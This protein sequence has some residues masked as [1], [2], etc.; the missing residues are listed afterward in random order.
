MKNERNFQIE[1]VAGVLVLALILALPLEK[2]EVVVLL[3]LI[4]SVIILETVNT[5]V[6]RMIDLIKPRANQQ[7]G[8][9]K[10]II[11]AVVFLVSVMSAVVGA[12][13]FWP[14]LF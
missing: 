2:W 1:V 12:I 3:V 13:I 14:Y 11:A 5:F 8:I 6:E 4:F 10:D 7:A 9:L